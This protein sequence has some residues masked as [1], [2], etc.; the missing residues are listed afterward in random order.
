VED[1]LPSVVSKQA[2]APLKLFI[3]LDRYGL[4]EFEASESAIARPWRRLFQDGADPGT[5]SYVLIRTPNQTTHVLGSFCETPGGRLLFFPGCKGRKLSNRFNRESEISSS[6]EGVVDH[7][8]LE[9]HSCRCHITQVLPTG[10]RNVALKLTQRPEVNSRMRA[11]FGITLRSLDSLDSV[12]GKLW[13]T[14]DCPVSDGKRRL[15]IFRERGAA[16]RV[17]QL[18]IPDV[19]RNSF[20]QINFFIDYEPTQTRRTVVTFLPKGPPELRSAIKIPQTMTAQ[21]QGLN[22]QEGRAMVKMH[23]IVWNG[24]P[25]VDVAFGF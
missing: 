23:P 15:T 22:I 5:I 9:P 4:G 20:L 8:T 7:I 11:W 19:A 6:L 16:S 18:A 1:K 25:T 3:N 17:C 21:L 10:E 24:A 2:Q 14:A 12:P 13:F